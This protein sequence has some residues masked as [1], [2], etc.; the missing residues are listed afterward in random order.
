MM[1]PGL[2]TPLALTSIRN[3]LEQK[4]STLV[5]E[6]GIWPKRLLLLCSSLQAGVEIIGDFSRTLNLIWTHTVVEFQLQ[7]EMHI[8]WGV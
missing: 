6:W 1:T 2:P 8:I 5:M 4:Y 7:G 3:I